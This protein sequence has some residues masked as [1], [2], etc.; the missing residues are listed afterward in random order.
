MTKFSSRLK[1]YTVNNTFSVK[2][3]TKGFELQPLTDEYDDTIE[4]A[5]DKEAYKQAIED[6]KNREALLIE[7]M[8]K[9]T[10]DE[11]SS[12]ISDYANKYAV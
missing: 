3:T 11:F 9:I 8:S 2:Q 7:D 1:Q 5:E 6:L 12:L 4:S 10:V